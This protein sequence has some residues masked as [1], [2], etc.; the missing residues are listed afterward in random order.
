MCAGRIAVDPHSLITS[1]NA[2][3]CSRVSLMVWRSGRFFAGQQ[4]FWKQLWRYTL[5]SQPTVGILTSVMKSR[6]NCLPQL[7]QYTSTSCADVEA[8]EA[9]DDAA[10]FC[11]SCSSLTCIIGSGSSLTCSSCSS[12]TC[13]IG[14]GSSLTGCQMTPSAFSLPSA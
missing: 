7:P 1:M 12:L 14:S 13:I 3:L 9:G 11:S 8:R 4:F 5:S 2:I 10:A 6:A